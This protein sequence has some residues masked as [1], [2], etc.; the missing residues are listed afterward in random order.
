MRNDDNY[1]PSALIPVMSENSCRRRGGLSVP[2]SNFAYQRAL[3]GCDCNFNLHPGASRT[4]SAAIDWVSDQLDCCRLVGVGVHD[5]EGL[6]NCRT[7]VVSF[8]YY[9]TS[10]WLLP[11]PGLF[12]YSLRFIAVATKDPPTLLYNSQY[13]FTTVSTCVSRQSLTS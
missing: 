10:G 12:S 1:L 11:L 3:G 2:R 7:S 9:D 5:D 6:E 8:R 4:T 13:C